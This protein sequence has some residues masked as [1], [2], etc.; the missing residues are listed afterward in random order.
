MILHLYLN[1]KRLKDLAVQLSPALKTDETESIGKEIALNGEV[2][3]GIPSWMEFL[4]FKGSGKLGSSGK[5][6]MSKEV[7]PASIEYA[8]LR[9]FK[10]KIQDNSINFISSGSRYADLDKEE[11]LVRIKGKFRLQVDG[12]DGLERVSNFS[13][14][15]YTEWLASFTDFTV[16]L[17]ASQESYTGRT[18]IFQCLSSADQSLN[19]EVLGLVTSTDSDADIMHVLRVV[20]IYFGVEINF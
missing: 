13:E 11:N 19:L 16:I 15:V 8:L 12:E 17:G 7:K 9:I 2:E 6:V 14:Q 4:G 18:P 20:P 3:G 1:E 5:I 10:E